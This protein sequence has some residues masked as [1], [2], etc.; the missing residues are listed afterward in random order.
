M[1]LKLVFC[2]DGGNDHVVVNVSGKCV[3]CGQ[4]FSDPEGD[5]DDGA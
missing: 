5:D 1:A 3:Y 4:D 2:K